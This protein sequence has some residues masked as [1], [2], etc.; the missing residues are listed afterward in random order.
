[1]IWSKVFEAYPPYLAN[2]IITSILIK[3]EKPKKNLCQKFVTFKITLDILFCF[4]VYGTY[5][6][7]SLT[8]QDTRKKNSQKKNL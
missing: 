4:S 6:K 2:L 8:N 7:C 5:D 3:L 1:M